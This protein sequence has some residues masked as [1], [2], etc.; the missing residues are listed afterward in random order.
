MRCEA[1]PNASCSSR[2]MPY[3][4]L[5]RSVD[6]PMD[7]PSYAS[8][9]P[10]NAMWSSSVTSPYLYPSRCPTSRCGALVIDSM[11]PA[12]TMSNSPARISWS[13]SAIASRPDRHTLLTVN[14]GTVIGMSAAT[15][16]WRADICPDPA[17]STCPMITYCT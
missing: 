1:A 8:V 6:S 11:P 2:V 12:T 13:A 4:L 17:W 16:A 9:S 10:S 7:T 15:A 3:R 5:C 14:A